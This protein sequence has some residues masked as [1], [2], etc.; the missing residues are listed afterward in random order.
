MKIKKVYLF[1]VLYAVVILLLIFLSLLFIDRSMP[2]YTLWKIEDDKINNMRFKNLNTIMKNEDTKLLNYNG[3][4]LTKNSKKTILVL[5]DS[6]I[7]GDGYDNINYTWWKQLQLE[8]YNRGYYDVSIEASGISGDSTYD[9]MKRLTETS[10]INDVSPDLIIIN[11]I[12]NDPELDDEDNKLTVKTIKSSDYFE[13][14]ILKVFKNIYP[15]I[16]YKI[17]NSLDSKYKY[18]NYINGKYNDETGYPKGVW[19]D[20]IIN[21]YWINQYKKKAIIPL[22]NYLN[23][24]DIKSFVVNSP[25]SFNKNMKE[26]YRVFDLFNNAGIKTYNLFD[27]LE[28]VLK[29]NKVYDKN[30]KINPVNSHPGT[31]YTKYYAIY[32]AD[33][34]ERDYREILGIKYDEKIEYPISINDY[35]PFSANLKKNDE[36]IY[37]FDYKNSDLLYMPIE[38]NY[39]KL[40]LE[41]PVRLS[42]IKLDLAKDLEATL[43]LTYLDEKLGY[44]TQKMYKIG[45]GLEF[46]LDDRLVTSINIH[47]DS[48]KNINNNKITLY[49]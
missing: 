17:N 16:A 36:N 9:E 40:S 25:L 11:Y 27:D 24:I 22:G 30:K 8:L 29:N 14:G 41:Y 44:D 15:N 39:I 4:S 47:I 45:T 21:D 10:L 37:Y 43:Y 33:I 42:K 48:D 5:G 31:A 28:R 3:A 38:E 2:N 34:L 35:L 1:G 26:R 6:Y 23:S 18:Y 46:D 32:I 12:T 49:K 13:N 19:N 7:F 20:I